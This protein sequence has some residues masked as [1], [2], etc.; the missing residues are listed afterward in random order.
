MSVELNGLAALWAVGNLL[1]LAAGSVE[2]VPGGM[3][4]VSAKEGA[5]VL[6]GEECWD[7]FAHDCEGHPQTC[8]GDAGVCDQVMVDGN[9]TWKCHNAGKERYVRGTWTAKWWTCENVE[10]GVFVEHT[11]PLG[12]SCFRIW[13]C[14]PDCRFIDESNIHVCQDGADV[15]HAGLHPNGCWIDAAF[16]GECRPE[17]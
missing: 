5:A 8:D 6:G 4:I 11:Y 15:E 12:W 9:T 2:S 3:T 10:V 14:P 13:T 16:W 17:E 1:I 7:E